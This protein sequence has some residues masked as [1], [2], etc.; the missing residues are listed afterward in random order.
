ML[1]N[2]ISRDVVVFSSLGGGKRLTILVPGGRAYRGLTGHRSSVPDT[3]LMPSL[4]YP[5]EQIVNLFHIPP[6]HALNENL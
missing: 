3:G 1:I 6:P 4:V 2:V 5:Q